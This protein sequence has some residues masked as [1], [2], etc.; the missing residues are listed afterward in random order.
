MRKIALTLSQAVEGFVLEKRAQQL[1]PHTL[2]SYQKTLQRLQEHL[3]GDP[4]L[5]DVTPQ[6]I[7]VFLTQLG[8]CA[9]APDGIAPRPAK[10]LSKKSLLNVH[11]ALSSFWTWATREGHADRHIVRAIPRPVPEKRVIVPLTKDD[12]Q[13]MLDLCETT[14]SYTRPG[15]RRCANTRPTGV[16]DRAIIHLLLDTGIRASELCNLNIEH[17]D[18]NN[19]RLKVFGKGAKERI[20]HVG[21][22]TTKII[23]RYLA[24]RPAAEPGDPLFIAADEITRR[25]TRTA[26]YKIIRRL[27]KRAGITPPA[28][29]HRFR[30]TFAINFLRNGGDV[31]SLQA[32]LG[33]SSL[34][35][36]K[37]YL[38]I[39]Q[40]DTE[41]A[42]RRASPVDNWRL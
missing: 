31:Y 42:H 7:N 26:L 14:R 27:G 5:D 2:Y 40:T 20:V 39:A 3:I 21:R 4:L 8:E 30:H 41:A 29:P 34:E 32:L 12:I 23:W 25:M 13:T 11:G 33:H 15:K 38:A 19:Q 36:V 35:M 9:V 28:Y 16:R 10:S 22:R 37:R 24:T 6:D 18:V 1:R 17:L